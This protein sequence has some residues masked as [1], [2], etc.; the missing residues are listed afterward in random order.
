[1][2]RR[3]L[4]L[5]ATTLTLAGCYGAL[6]S[7]E[8]EE[9]G[10]DAFGGGDGAGNGDSDGD[11]IPDWAD[12]DSDNDGIPVDEETD[13]GTD[14][15]N[16]DS[17]GDGWTDLQEQVCG[18]DPFDPQSTCDGFN[19]N[20][21]GNAVSVV[22]VTYETQVQLGDVHFIL[23]ETGS[24]QG[25]L[26][27]VKDNFADVA[28]EASLLIPDLTFGVSSFDDYNYGNMGSGSDKP[29][30]PRQQQTSDLAAA[31][32][33][34]DGL[35][36]GGG[37]DWPES[38]V[39]ALYQAATGLGYNQGCH[40]TWENNYSSADDVRPFISHPLDAFGGAVSG[41]YDQAADPDG[42]GAPNFGP[43]VVGTGS[44]GGNGYRQGAVPI[45]VYTTDADV[46]NGLFP[47]YN[48]GP[49]GSGMLHSSC[50]PDAV[51]FLLD[52][53]LS[54]VNAKTIGVAAR[55]SDAVPAMN[56]IAEMTGSYFD[57]DG[58]G[59]ADLGEHMVYL[60]NSYDIVDKVLEGIEAFTLNVTYDM[61]MEAE[62][63]GGT[64]LNIE[65]PFYND[66]SAMNTK[67]F[68][69]TLSPEATTDVTM[70]SD[71]VWVIPTTLYGDGAV[72]LAQWDLIFQVT[73][74]P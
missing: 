33:A 12:L 13:N 9:I 55:T 28:V 63:P 38:T 20:I 30:H 34:L 70:F 15:T 66:V 25:T 45:L 14:P 67:A 42:D 49:K 5:F 29:Y 18:S 26:D 3:L 60:S 24:M 11:G 39:E 10:D 32:T 71:T 52:A 62:A 22:V 2:D 73:N 6:G 64:L 68:T 74:S 72:I 21:V 48:Q 56:E 50:D 1:M 69:L 27:N 37:W 35:Y 53:A 16:P 19:G 23:D 31:Q 44:L 41:T 17:D 46:R 57:Y 65:P 36:A 58:D 43:G 47:N 61:T 51:P 8:E 54:N 4:L 40:S 7:V 59:E